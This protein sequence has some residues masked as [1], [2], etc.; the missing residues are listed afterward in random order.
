MPGVATV[1]FS[2]AAAGAV[3]AAM[4]AQASPRPATIVVKRFNISILPCFVFLSSAFQ[5]EFGFAR[6]AHQRAPDALAQFGKAR[7]AQGG[8]R[9]RSR[10]VDGDGLV[11]A[12]RPALEYDDAV[13][14]Q[15]GFLDRVRD[16]DHRGR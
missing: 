9:A 8:A 7:L 6:L 13:A 3:G 11:D 1:S 10:Q 2:T 5:N 12:R 14:E 16:E 4:S 15:H